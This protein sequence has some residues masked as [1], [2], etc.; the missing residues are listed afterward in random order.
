VIALNVG[1][2]LRGFSWARLGLAAILLALAPLV[3]P[4]PVPGERAVLVLALLVA[5]ASAGAV[6]LLPPPAQPRRL[7][8]FICLLDTALIT[9]VVAA[10]GGP[11]SIFTFL[12][13]LGV[14][15]ACVLLS[16]TR[17]LGIAAVSIVL[18]TGI[19]V[20]RTVLPLIQFF[21]APQETTALEVVTMFLN[22]ATLLVVAILAG[23]LG[24]QYRA[25]RQELETRQKDLRDLQ[26]FKDLVF[27]SVGT[28]LIALDRDHQVTAFNRAAEEITGVVAPHAIG[29]AW[30]SLIGAAI[31]LEPIE[32]VIT[33]NPRASTRHEAVLRRPD[34]T[35]VPVR[36]TFS[37]LR[38]GE[39]ERLGLISACED[40]SAIREM[41]S[42]MR[43][44]D[45][46]A[47]VGRMAANIAH[48]IRNPLAS[49][50]GAIEV[51]TSPLTADD[52]RERLSQIVARESERLNHIIKNFLEYA[53]P[54][55]LA[56][57]TFDVA[58]AAE[59]VLLLLEHRASP[60][61]LKVLREFAPSIPWAVD[62]QQFRQ[63][64]W[65][66]CLNAVEAMP[67]GGEL[68]VSVAARGETLEVAV[69]DTGDGIAAGDVAHVFEPFFSTKPE[70]TGLGLALV[71]R[72][73]QDHGG[74]IDVRSSPGL[75]TTFTVTLPARNA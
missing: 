27:Q 9:A 31:P 47:T 34:G 74:E 60:G 69:S 35:S 67:E 68:R 38:S 3:S 44:A 72:I 19:V 24:E 55:P 28:G 64:L 45:R 30:S 40:L 71:H 2:P 10:T 5:I 75:G 42:R 16:R 23:G 1:G 49:L 63:I 66:L 29:Q 43:Q 52:A 21:D 26:A 62:A 11:R 8:W 56:L 14:T 6:L 4:G 36:M 17:G 61:S 48:E 73:V 59:E 41:E 50:T 46:L 57:A 22:A 58:A 70:G 51:L 33:A 39:G 7:T 25:T 18:Y 32:A 20:A 65:N 15:A 53:R 54:A 12:Y 13:V 37:A